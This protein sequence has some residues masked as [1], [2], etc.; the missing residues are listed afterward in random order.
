MPNPLDTDDISNP[1][2]RD[3]LGDRFAE[4]IRVARPSP[5]LQ[6]QANDLPLLLSSGGGPAAPAPGVLNGQV[7]RC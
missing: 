5:L 2:T 7:E 1:L 4:T 3:T 6:Q